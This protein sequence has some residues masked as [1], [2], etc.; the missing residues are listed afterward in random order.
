M[1]ILYLKRTCAIDPNTSP[2]LYKYTYNASF[3]QKGLW[4]FVTCL[5]K[6]S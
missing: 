1:G 3:D 2:F 5:F 6:S 4:Q